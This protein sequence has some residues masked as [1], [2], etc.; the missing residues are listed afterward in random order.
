M[1]LPFSVFLTLGL[2]SLPHSEQCTQPTIERLRLEGTL[3][4]HLFQ[5]QGHLSTISG[6]LRIKK[7]FKSKDNKSICLEPRQGWG[8]QVI[9]HSQHDNWIWGGINKTNPNLKT[10]FMHVV[11]NKG[12]RRKQFKVVF[13]GSWSRI[14]F[15][16]QWFQCVCPTLEFYL[17]LELWFRNRTNQE[18]T[19][20]VSL[21][22]HAENGRWKDN[23]DTISCCKWALVSF[24]RNW[25]VTSLP[26]EHIH[27][28]LPSVRV[29]LYM[30]ESRSLGCVWPEPHSVSSDSDK[31][32][33][34]YFGHCICAQK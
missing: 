19:D 20:G 32:M 9:L 24:I 21:L 16:W 27:S 29:M 12:G 4:I 10:S 11:P 2:L 7:T 13:A 1:K 33:R 18:T 17:L 5:G 14:D 8:K 30:A 3:G 31:L 6:C 28:S 34:I 15:Q 23:E 26:D 25:N 22:M